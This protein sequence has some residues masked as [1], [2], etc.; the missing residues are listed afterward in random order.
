MP[1]IIA[2][3]FQDSIR[4]SVEGVINAFHCFFDEIQ[5]KMAESLTQEQYNA[6]WKKVE[7]QFHT[8]EERQ[9]VRES[10]KVN[11]IDLKK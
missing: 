3:Q 8:V 6:F 11:H 7:S 5:S 1:I 2:L 9:L 10:L 4:Q